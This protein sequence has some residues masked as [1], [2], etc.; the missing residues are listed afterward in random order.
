MADMA[1]SLR[2]LKWAKTEDGQ[3]GINHPEFLTPPGKA[4]EAE[5]PEAMTIPELQEFLNR[6]RI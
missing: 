1:N 6:K 4:E 3:K 2:W 5:E